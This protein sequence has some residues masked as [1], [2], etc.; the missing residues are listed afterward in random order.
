MIFFVM[1]LFP[2][3]EPFAGACEVVGRVDA[4]RRRVDE[5]DV[6][7]H[8]RL[9]RAQLLEPLALLQRRGRQGDEARERGAPIGVEADVVQQ[10]ALAPRRAGAGEIERAQPAGADLGPDRL[11]DVG[12]VALGLAPDRRRQRGDVARRSSSGARRRAPPRGSMVGRS[13][14]TLTTMS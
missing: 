13:P 9:Q 4:E 11:D 10:V 14:C 5:R 6:D 8:A 12:V 1:V 7:A 2:R 3:R